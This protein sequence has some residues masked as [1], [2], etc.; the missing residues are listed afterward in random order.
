ME[1]GAENIEAEIKLWRLLNQQQWDDLKK[2]FCEEFEYFC[3]QTEEKMNLD[4]FIAVNKSFNGVR[5]FENINSF[6]EYN[7]WEHRSNIV[8]V[9]YVESQQPEMPKQIFY[10]ISFVIVDDG[11]IVEMTEYNAETMHVPS[12][13]KNRQ[14]K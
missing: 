6:H 4:E 11:K 7:Q 1:Y 10:K 9:F 2:I 5:N 14:L 8:S 13:M 12:W 3:P